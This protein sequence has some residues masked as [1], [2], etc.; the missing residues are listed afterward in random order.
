M[1][2]SIAPIDAVLI[3]NY[4]NAELP[5]AI[6]ANA[7]IGGPSPAVLGTGTGAVPRHGRRRPVG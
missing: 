6:P 1:D 2:G 3:I 5:A 7:P 4:L